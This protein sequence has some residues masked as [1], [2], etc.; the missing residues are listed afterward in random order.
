[1]PAGAA[2]EGRIAAIKV[3]KSAFESM[4]G[5]MKRSGSLET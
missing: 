2:Y 3:E 4:P 1:M 5:G